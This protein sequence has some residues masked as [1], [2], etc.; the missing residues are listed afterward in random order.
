MHQAA[1]AETRCD[2][3]RCYTERIQFR[4]ADQEDEPER[5]QYFPPLCAMAD[6]RPPWFSVRDYFVH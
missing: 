1:K 2:L 6:A 5:H 3:N 4:D